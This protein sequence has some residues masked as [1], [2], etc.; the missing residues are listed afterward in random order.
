[1]KKIWIEDEYLII[2]GGHSGYDHKVIF[3]K[4]EW[5]HHYTVSIRDP[6]SVQGPDLPIYIEKTIEGSKK[7]HHVLGSGSFNFKQFVERIAPNVQPRIEQVDLTNPLLKDTEVICL[8]EKF[9]QMFSQK[10]VHLTEAVLSGLQP[11]QLTTFKDH[12]FGM[13]LPTST[14]SNL[15]MLVS[16]AGVTYNLSFLGLSRIERVLNA[17]IVF[18][19]IGGQKGSTQEVI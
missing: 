4:P 13:A 3:K 19:H 1:M 7:E 16:G 15:G 5:Y 2:F 8:D 14:Q 10:E 12:G 18:H 17:N 9:V 11:T 6:A